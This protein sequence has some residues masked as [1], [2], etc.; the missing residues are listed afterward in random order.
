MC[1]CKLPGS[2]AN[3]SKKQQVKLILVMHFINSV[4]SKYYLTWDNIK[5]I[6]YFPFFILRSSESGVFYNDSHLIWGSRMPAAV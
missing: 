4:D 5:I 2:H 3:K 6:R 1:N